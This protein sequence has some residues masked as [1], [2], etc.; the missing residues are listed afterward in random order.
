MVY[1]VL[2]LSGGFNYGGSVSGNYILYKILQNCNINFKVCGLN[3]L[4]SNGLDFT[5]SDFVVKDLSNLPDHKL[6]LSSG[7]DLPPEV[8]KKICLKHNSKYA[9]SA[10]THW[11]YANTKHNSYPELNGDFVGDVID[12]RL[13]FYDK[14]ETY[15]ITHSTFST[16]VHLGSS[17]KHLPYIQIPLPFEEIDVV[18]DFLEFKSNKKTIL[19]GT[20]QPQTQRKGL[21]YFQDILNHLYE[22]VDNSLGNSRLDTKFN[23]HNFGIL[24]DRLELSKIYQASDVFALTTL[25]DAGPMMATECVKNNTPLVAFDRSIALDLIGEQGKNGYIANECK[26][27][28]QKLYDILYNN[29]F[30]MDL[31]YV[32]NFNSE[33]VVYKKFEQFIKTIK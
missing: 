19:W 1:D 12:R 31:D 27:Y 15:I 22:I 10:M 29:N 25:A 28:S 30:H 21:Y 7:D 17:L 16:S 23:V 26:E 20:T 11:M 14:I 3:G 13:S 5:P 6:L 4:P 2:Y 24:K 33:K 32:T 8:L 9:V 18:E